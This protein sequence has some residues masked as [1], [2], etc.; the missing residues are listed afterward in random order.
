MS[1]GHSSNKGSEAS[2]VEVFFSRDSLSLTHTH[3]IATPSTVKPMVG[4]VRRARSNRVRTLSRSTRSRDLDDFPSRDDDDDD[5]VAF[6]VQL[7]GKES[8]VKKDLD[9]IGH[10]W[11]N[12]SM[13]SSESSFTGAFTGALTIFDKARTPNAWLGKDLYPVDVAQAYAILGEWKQHHALLGFYA[14]GK[15][16]T[17]SLFEHMHEK[18]VRPQKSSVIGEGLGDTFPWVKEC[19]EAAKLLGDLLATDVYDNYDSREVRVVMLMNAEGQEKENSEFVQLQ[20]GAYLGIGVYDSRNEKFFLHAIVTGTSHVQNA[21]ALDNEKSSTIEDFLE[22]LKVNFP[23]TTL[24][25]EPM[26]NWQNGRYFIQSLERL[27]LSD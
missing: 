27:I 23:G 10:K 24:S 5:D 14:Q 1:G 17:S 4:L 2:E 21:F 26:K 8:T 19:M 22:A 3:I 15:S 7:P 25:L 9:D 11:N 20:R 13:D 6:P 16:D 18:N 12:N